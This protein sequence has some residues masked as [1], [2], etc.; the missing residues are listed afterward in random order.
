VKKQFRAVICVLCLSLLPALSGCRT[1][2]TSKYHVVARL[3]EQKLAIAFRAGDTACDAV[4]NAL[5]VLEDRGDVSRLSRDWF[6]DDL[7]RLRGDEGALDDWDREAS[8]RVFI[9][10][11]DAAHL[12]FSGV[13]DALPTGFDV[14]LA[15]AVC[16]ELGWTA[17]FIAVDVSNAL[18]ELKSGNV[19][20]VWGALALP[21][22]PPPE[23]S[24]SPVYMNNTL[25]VATLLGSG[26]SGKNT[27]GGKTLAVSESGLF[28]FAL[29]SDS[30]ITS[31]PDYIVVLPGGVDD[32]FT[33]L[34]AGE[35][36]AIV[37]DLAGIEY[38]S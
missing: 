33:A 31:A 27:L 29:S 26:I 11:Y 2:N 14:E 9:V 23:L 7:S 32:C 6:D 24:F 22:S 25:V 30:S 28:Y 18:V 13:E 21:E 16:Q 36:D 1:G 12:P 15:R 37:T 8:A 19:D 38:H 3:S 5:A 17:R 4:T 10:G 35:V 20:C 34:D